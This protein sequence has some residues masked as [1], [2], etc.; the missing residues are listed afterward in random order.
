MAIDPQLDEILGRDPGAEAPAPEAQAPAAE[1]ETAPAAEADV[2]DDLAG[3]PEDTKFDAAYVKKLRQ[4][5]AQYRTRAKQYDV[6][7]KYDEQDRQ[8]WTKMAELYQTDPVAAAEYMAAIADGVRKAQAPEPTPVAGDDQPLTAAQ[9]QAMLAERDQ[10]AAVAAETVRIE[11]EAKSLGYEV[12]SR[13]YKYLIQTAIDDTGGDI[14]AAHAAI[15]AERQA[16]IDQYVG[17][18]A[19]EQA[20]SPVAPAAGA[21]TMPSQEKEMPKNFRDAKA[22]I[23]EMLENSR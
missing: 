12:G 16:I 1:A 14:A 8:V 23:Y 20:G 18:K 21:G 22:A 9:V 5:A 19:R 10:K 6:F 7:E 4:E 15:E 11:A 13:Q 2:L 3:V 17:G